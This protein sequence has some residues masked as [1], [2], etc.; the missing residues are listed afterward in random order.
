MDE[1]LVKTYI[2]FLKKD[3]KS[4]DRSEM[5]MFLPLRLP[6]KFLHR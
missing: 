1:D 5:A 4:Q 6:I 3:V 2:R